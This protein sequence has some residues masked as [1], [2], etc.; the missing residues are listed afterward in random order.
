ML[1][2]EEEVEDDL[3]LRAA[4]PITPSSFNLAAALEV[5][6]IPSSTGSNGVP[7]L[8]PELRTELFTRGAS[9]EVLCPPPSE[10][11]NRLAIS[12]SRFIV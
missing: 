11:P 6:S 7:T 2:L 5:L 8:P 4:P 10:S 1:E 9:F 3:S 12:S